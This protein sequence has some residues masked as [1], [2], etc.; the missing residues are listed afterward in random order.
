MDA[1]QFQ[2]LLTAMTNG[3]QAMAQQQPQ[4]NNAPE[5]TVQMPTF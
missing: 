2:Q 3:L 1:V 4:A 5:I